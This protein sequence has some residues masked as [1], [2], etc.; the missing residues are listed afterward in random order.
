MNNKCSNE[1]LSSCLVRI[2]SELGRIEDLRSKNRNIA[3]IVSGAIISFSL[4]QSEYSVVL[5]SNLLALLVAFACWIQDFQLHKYRHGWHG[6]DRRLRRYINGIIN[7]QEL[8][9][10]RYDPKEEKDIQDKDGS[11]HRGA[12][13]FSKSSS[14]TFI[15]LIFGAISVGVF[16]YF[17]P[18][19]GTTAN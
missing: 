18:F 1:I 10:M 8:N 13:L 19:V 7:K 9:L 11:I 4:T 16:R 3:L 2:G 6:I 14:F 15:I 17:Y 5:I 12:K